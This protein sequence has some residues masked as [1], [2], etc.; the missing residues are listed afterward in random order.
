LARPHATFGFT[1]AWTRESPPGQEDLPP[2][3]WGSAAPRGVLGHASGRP[4]QG[5]QTTQ[6]LSRSAPLS[7]RTPLSSNRAHSTRRLPVG[8]RVM[9]R[10]CDHCAARRC[11]LGEPR[12]DPPDRAGLGNVDPAGQGVESP[13]PTGCAHMPPVEGRAAPLGRTPSGAGSACGLS[14]LPT[15]WTMVICANSVR[16][17]P[18][19]DRW[20]S[21]PAGEIPA[22][23]AR[24][25]AAPTPGPRPSPFR[26]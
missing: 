24:T 26:G 25:I 14:K 6:P 12:S 2:L 23:S 11:G 10:A 22:S 15:A 7:G 3:G 5:I 9:A 18:T 16:P 20:R 1:S 13:F 19:R 4:C 8:L 17:G 21:T